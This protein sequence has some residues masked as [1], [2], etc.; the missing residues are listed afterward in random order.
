MGEARGSGFQRDNHGRDRRRLKT[1]Q[2]PHR[3]NRNALR[4]CAIGFGGDA[5]EI[6]ADHDRSLAS[7]ESRL[8]RL[9]VLAPEQ[10]VT[11]NRYVTPAGRR[12]V[13]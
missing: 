9:G 3:Q 11:R 5:I 6:A 13:V 1:E 2:R 7:V 8:E 4:I 10:R 12:A